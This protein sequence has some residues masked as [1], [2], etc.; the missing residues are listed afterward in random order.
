MSEGIQIGLFLVAGLDYYA[1]GLAAFLALYKGDL[2]TKSNYQCFT[3]KE[4]FSSLPLLIGA[5]G[6][7]MHEGYLSWQPPYLMKHVFSILSAI[8]KVSI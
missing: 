6:L 7:T 5:A 3:L 8:L 1:A 2:S 4:H